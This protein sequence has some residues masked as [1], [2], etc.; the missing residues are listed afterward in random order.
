LPAARFS[1]P[2]IITVLKDD[3]GGGRVRAG[4]VH[5]WATALQVAIATPLLVLSGMTLDRVRA[6]ATDYLGFD[7][8]TLYSAPLHLDAF[9]NENAW[10]RVRAARDAL[11][12]TGG[13]ASVTLGDGT[14]LDFRYRVTRVATVPAAHE[15]SSSFAPPPRC[16][17]G[18]NRIFLT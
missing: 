4:R 14:P 3:A 13:V 5:R 2:V 8:E 7:A 18:V 9:E 17:T 6:T 11:V 1:R 10:S 12:Q 16:A 15:A